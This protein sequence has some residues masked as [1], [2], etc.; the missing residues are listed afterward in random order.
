MDGIFGATALIVP[1][2]LMLH[3]AGAAS[4]P[5]APEWCALR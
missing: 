5:A 4:A 1:S 2:S 3:I